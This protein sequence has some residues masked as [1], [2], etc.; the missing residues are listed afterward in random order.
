MPA[1]IQS[2]GN[3]KPSRILIISP[4]FV[5][6]ANSEAFCGGKV[7]LGLLK[8][9]CQ[10][11]VLTLSP[12]QSPGY[13]GRRDESK[14]WDLLKGYTYQFP[15]SPK[16]SKLYAIDSA[17]RYKTLAYARWIAA[18]IEKSQM[19]HAANKFDIVYSRSLPMV[20]HIAGFWLSKYLGIPWIA[21]INDP[22][23]WHHIPLLEKK[24]AS[25]Y[26]CVSQSV[27]NYW[28]RRTIENADLVTYPSDR[29]WK[30]HEKISGIHHRAEVLAHIGY[31]REV[32]PD[33]EVFTI[34]HAGVLGLDTGLRRSPL[35]ILQALKIVQN[36]IPETNGKLRVFFIGGEEAGIR[37]LVKEYELD[38]M[39]KCTGMLHY[40]ESLK[41]IASAHLCLLLEMEMDEGIYLPSKLADY[42]TAGKPVLAVSPKDGVLSDLSRTSGIF[43]VD[44]DDPKAIG[45]AI[46]R[47]YNAFKN[48]ELES[49]AP[50]KD[51]RLKFDEENVVGTFLDLASRLRNLRPVG[52][53]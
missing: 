1:V 33:R 47:Y 41:C 13:L 4:Y 22:W 24:K 46:I 37:S 7:V 31:G 48:N 17:L 43:R 11:A 5:P 49:Y 29:L 52:A 35:P 23:D 39:V 32:T 19:L 42:V 14:Y 34:V 36:R 51:L 53:S 6:T 45:D 44:S 15:A 2:Y 3:E 21:N 50:S 16:T 8:R 27:S 18:V 20:A 12:D 9:H 28:L 10:V 30:F 25:L 26:Q 38:Q 40:E